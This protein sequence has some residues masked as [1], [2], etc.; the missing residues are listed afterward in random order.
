MFVINLRC[1][2]A[3]ESAEFYP[4]AITV[5]VKYRTNFGIDQA[6]SSA[7]SFQHRSAI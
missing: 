4:K 3:E 2:F 1:S 6:L 5:I 7:F